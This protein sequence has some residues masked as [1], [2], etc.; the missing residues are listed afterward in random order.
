MKHVIKERK[1]KIGTA[2][3]TSASTSGILLL[4][5]SL[6]LP[7]I[8]GDFFLG[9]PVVLVVPGLILSIIGI[10]MTNKWG[11]RPLAHQSLRAGLRGLGKS[12][13]AYH[14]HFPAPHL[15]ICSHGVFT[16][17]PVTHRISAS[18]DSDRWRRN[19]SLLRKLTIPFRQDSLGN[20]TFAATIDASR[21]QRWLDRRLP[22]HGVTVQPVV[23]FTHENAYI[24]VGETSVPVLYAD[25]R[26]P[27]LRQWIRD[28][29]QPTLSED[30]IAR[31]EAA[32]KIG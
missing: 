9:P 22:G 14:Y 24:E 31:L 18:V 3:A 32:A 26:K 25:K 27:S 20:P 19:E 16:L 1:V 12:A 15:L 21:M 8:E 4:I 7:I 28:Q 13:T 30:Q 29:Q 23:V 17:T 6:V 2:I 11:R 10:Q 5:G